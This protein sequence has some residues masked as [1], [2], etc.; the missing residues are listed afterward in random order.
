MCCLDSSQESQRVCLNNSRL[1]VNVVSGAAIEPD[2]DIGKQRKKRGMGKGR[3]GGPAAD[4]EVDTAQPATGS[5]TPADALPNVP[6]P[7]NWY[8]LPHHLYNTL[9]HSSKLLWR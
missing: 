7:L 4:M 6:P 5:A 1:H 8:V 9:S 2:V 3:K